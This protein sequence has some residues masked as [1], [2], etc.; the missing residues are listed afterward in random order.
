MAEL[1]GRDAA[2]NISEKNKFQNGEKFIAIISDAASI[3]ISLQADKRVKNQRRYI[4]MP[5][6]QFSMK[7]I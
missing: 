3:G 4:N 7:D 5:L 6:L 2:S 1:T